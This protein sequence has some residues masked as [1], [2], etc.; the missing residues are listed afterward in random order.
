MSFLKSDP[1]KFIFNKENFLQEYHNLSN[2]PEKA[3][4]DHA[5]LYILEFQVLGN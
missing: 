2:N 4:R 5:N 3:I 1:S